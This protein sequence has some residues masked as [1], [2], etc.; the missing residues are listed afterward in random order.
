MISTVIQSMERGLVPDVLIRAGIRKLCSD[1]LRSLDQKSLELR[2][3]VSNSYIDLLKSSPIAVHTDAANEQHYEVPAD[4]FALCLGKNRKYSSAY[5]PAGCSSLD[6]A[7]DAALEITMARAQ[8]VDGMKILELGC[9]WGSLTLAMAKRFPNCQIVALSNSA[10]QR[11]YIETQASA[12]GFKN[13]KIITR[14]IDQVEGLESEF[15]S[16]DR[17]V[18]VEMFEHLRN[19]EQLFAR[20]S[21]WMK[22][23]GKL[24]VHVFTHQTYSYLFE[25]EG[26]DNWLGRYFFTGG[27]MPSHELFT[28]FQKDLILAQ[29]W[30]WDGTHYGRTAEAWLKNLDQNRQS[31]L[32]I[33]KKVY[34]DAEAKVWLQ[35]WRIFYLSC[36]ELFNYRKGSEWG[37]SHYLFTKRQ[38]VI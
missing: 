13:I 7:E 25:V 36:A 21:K 4:F 33:F 35:R 27:Q 2:Q 23:D 34:G 19:Y 11:E 1:R 14:N 28:H 37:V 38:G 26:E 22:E 16:F 30:A 12:R 10:S 17:I 18:S 15:G 3:N 20:V 31:I 32:A 9:G 24:F 6:E 5:W 29:Q 8:I